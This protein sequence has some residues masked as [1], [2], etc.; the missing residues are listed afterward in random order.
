MG[1]VSR[2]SWELEQAA[3]DQELGSEPLGDTVV[4]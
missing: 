1:E 3:W 4:P 2:G